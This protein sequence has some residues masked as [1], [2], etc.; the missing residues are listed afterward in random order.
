MGR[1]R[2]STHREIGPEAYA[3]GSICGVLWGSQTRVRGQ[4]Q[5]SGFYE[6]LRGSYLRLIGPLM[7]GRGDC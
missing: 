1:S 7:G 3:L 2:Q 6:A 5:N 4:Y